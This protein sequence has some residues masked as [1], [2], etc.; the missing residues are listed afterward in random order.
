MRVRFRSSVGNTGSVGI[1]PKTQ[2]PIKTHINETT[3]EEMTGV[4]LLCGNSE[5]C[6]SLQ[7]HGNTGQGKKN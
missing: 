1:G 5:R 4:R 7:P 3:R 2:P 6:G